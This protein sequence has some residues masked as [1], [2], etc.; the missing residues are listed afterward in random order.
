LIL[1]LPNKRAKVF[2]YAFNY[3]ITK[4]LTD[5]DD[6]TIWKLF[7][8]D[9][10]K[11]KVN[12]FMGP[13]PVYW[14]GYELNLLGTKFSVARGKGPN[15]KRIV[16][17]DIFKFFGCKFVTALRNWKVGEKELVDR[18]ELMK[19]KRHLF[20]KESPEA[21]EAYCIDECRC[22]AELA[23]RLIDAHDKAGL[24]LKS[25]FGA[26]SSGGAMLT[27]MGIK[28]KLTPIPE[29]MRHAVS[30]AFF[31]GRFEN[32]VIGGVEDRLDGWDISSAYPYHTTFLPC[33]VHAKWEYT[34]DRRKLDSARAAC[35]SYRLDSNTSITSWGPFPFREKNGTISYPIE[36]GGGWLWL[37]EY[38]EGERLFPH[39]KF[40]GAWVYSSDC[41]C[42]PFAAIPHYYLERIKLGKEGPGI[43]IKL[44]VNSVYG[45][46]AQSVGSAM[47]NNWI[48][49]G[50]IT[51]G[52]R[53]QILHMLGLHK[54]W[55]NMLMVATDG[56][57]TR[58]KLIPPT[59]KETGTTHTGKPLGGWEKKEAPRGIFFARPGIYF[60]MLPTDVDLDGIKA[61]G[62]GKDTMLDQ[63]H[64]IEAHWAVY[65]LR[66]NPDYVRNMRLPEKWRKKVSRYIDCAVGGVQRFCGAKTTISRSASKEG[67]KALFGKRE[68]HSEADL[69]T[70]RRS[71][72]YG[73]WITRENIMSFDPLPKRGKLMKD[74]LR[75]ELRRFPLDQKSI[76]YS[77]AVLSPEAK[78]M[79][80][81]KLE[82]FEQP[83]A[84][85]EDDMWGEEFT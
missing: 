1:S 54:D 30:S 3:D 37:E 58:E 72:N 76:P 16:I 18:M 56:I 63:W 4:I 65:G 66:P 84:G 64:I 48:W 50:M 21:V 5:V 36:S 45:K 6:K 83:D 35:V 79:I 42:K 41:G 62:L 14:K 9:Q 19:K 81:A 31:G 75:L 12:P 27:V 39:V 17:W 44:G 7:R 29:E 20:D 53:A 71:P 60:T 28:E 46:L 33:L 24:K 68:K 43:V 74:G 32:S 23:Y 13:L 69:F 77:K 10:R 49:A 82:A 67:V 59:P 70:Y 38:L 61:R 22:M 15:R 2:A 47:F 26:G 85:D 57:F 51:S 73:Q 11:R 55:S 40:E 25:Y 8:S 80:Q 78:A 52:C 34:N